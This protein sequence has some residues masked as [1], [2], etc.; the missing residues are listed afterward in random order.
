MLVL[1]NSDPFT[2]VAYVN[3]TSVDGVPLG[4]IIGG[5]TPDGFPLYVTWSSLTG[6]LDARNDYVEYV[7]LTGNAVT[8]TEWF[9]IVV[10]YSE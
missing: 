3:K 6:N 2:T 7:D 4:A 1:E 10:D 9:Y 8:S 5:Y